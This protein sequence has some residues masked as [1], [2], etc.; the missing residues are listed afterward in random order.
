MHK[1]IDKYYLGDILSMANI[2]VSGNYEYACLSMKK[3]FSGNDLQS[4]KEREKFREQFTLMMY[5]NSISFSKKLSFYCDRHT[6]SDYHAKKF[7]ERIW[8]W[9]FEKPWVWENQPPENLEEKRES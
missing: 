8:F 3:Y 5:D 9:V 6:E 1:K 7:L 4:Q 2:N